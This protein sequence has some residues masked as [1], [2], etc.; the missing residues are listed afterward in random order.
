MGDSEGTV[1]SGEGAIEVAL[2]EFREETGRSAAECSGL[3]VPAREPRFIELGSIVQRGGKRVFAWGFE[4]DWPPGVEV[5]SNTFPLEWPPRS[6]RR[7]EVPEVDRGGFFSIPA[8]RAKINPAQEP[9]IDR[10]IENLGDG[11]R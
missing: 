2:R 7:I 4:G 6:G 10:L 1:R 5:V 11:E 9:L 8:A 3:L